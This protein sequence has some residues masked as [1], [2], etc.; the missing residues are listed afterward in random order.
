MVGIWK[1]SATWKVIGKAETFGIRLKPEGL[2]QLFKM[3]ASAIYLDYTD[4][5]SVLG[6]NVNAFSDSLYSAKDVR[7]LIQISEQ[8]LLNKLQQVKLERNYVVE[9]TKLIRQSK[10]SLSIEKLSENLYVSK[11]Q[12]ERSVKGHLQ[13]YTTL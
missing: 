10:G 1:D 2:L 7:E 9:A 11:R 12:L 3:P 13:L 4:L 5:E 6:K 8:F